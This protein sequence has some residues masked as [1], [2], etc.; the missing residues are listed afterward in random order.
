MDA[1]RDSSRMSRR[2]PNRSRPNAFSGFPLFSE[3][4]NPN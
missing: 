2:L 4:L 1:E 3:L